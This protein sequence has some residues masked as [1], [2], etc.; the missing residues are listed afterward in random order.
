MGSYA[1]PA[2]TTSYAAAAPAVTMGTS[3]PTTY[4]APT[5]TTGFATSTSTYAD[6][7]SYAAAPTSYAAAPSMGMGG[8]QQ[9]GYGGMSLFDLLDTDHDG[10]ISRNEFMALMR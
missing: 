4:A 8:F 1:A 9:A 3:V 7:T 10:T 5:A 2:A 6:P